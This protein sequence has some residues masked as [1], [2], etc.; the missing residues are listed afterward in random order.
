MPLDVVLFICI[1]AIGYVAYL[2]GHRD[3]YRKGKDRGIVIG[4]Q[5]GQQ[6]W[7]KAME[8]KRGA[9]GKDEFVR[10]WTNVTTPAL[11]NKATRPRQTH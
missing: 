5:R 4:H 7:I 1:L 11:L 10:A 3:G 9:D 6:A 2:V 8:Q